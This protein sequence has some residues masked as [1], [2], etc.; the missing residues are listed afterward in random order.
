MKNLIKVIYITISTFMSVRPY[1]VR[2]PASGVPLPD[3][4]MFRVPESQSDRCRARQSQAAYIQFQNHMVRVPEAQSDC[5]EAEL[6][7]LDFKT[8][9][10]EFKKPSQTAAERGEAELRI[11]D[12]KSTWSEF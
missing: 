9:W 5:C 1:G 12:S 7:I 4:I 2:C 11:L 8:T 6:R 3:F 10:S